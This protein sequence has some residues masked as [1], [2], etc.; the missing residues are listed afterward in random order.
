MVAGRIGFIERNVYTVDYSIGFWCSR[1]TIEM[2]SML[3][4]TPVAVE[5]LKFLI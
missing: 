1:K 3:K 2:M 5:N 4:S